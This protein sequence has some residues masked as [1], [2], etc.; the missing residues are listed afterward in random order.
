MK[1]V[2]PLNFDKSYFDVN[3]TLGGD[4]ALV[5]YLPSMRVWKTVSVNDGLV[6]NGQGAKPNAS[7]AVNVTV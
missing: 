2:Q 6:V 7:K 1:L 4:I 3:D 5:P